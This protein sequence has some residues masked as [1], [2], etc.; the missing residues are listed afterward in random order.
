[1]YKD[2]IWYRKFEQAVNERRD[3]FSDKQWAKFQ[4]DHLLKVAN[5]VREFS[6]SCDTCRGYQHT[7]TRLEE[8]SQELPG[9]KAQRQYQ[10]GQLYQMG[11]HFV[12]E[13]Q[14]A[15]PKFFLRRW[16]RYG[17]FAGLGVGFVAMIIVGNLLLFPAATLLLTGLGAFYGY[18]Q[19]QKFVRERRLV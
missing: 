14:L 10:M 5:R 12:T 2:E 8:E 13:H 18:V 3:L 6:E 9:S 4:L 1:M 7:L 16:L 19:D 17:L 11:E 15:P